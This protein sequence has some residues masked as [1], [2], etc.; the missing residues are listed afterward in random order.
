MAKIARANFQKVVDV[1]GVLQSY[2]GGVRYIRS[3][4]IQKGEGVAQL[5]LVGEEDDVTVPDRVSEWIANA[6]SKQNSDSESGMD[7]NVAGDKLTNAVMGLSFTGTM[8]SPTDG[9]FSVVY[10]SKGVT[11]GYRTG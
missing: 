6:S 11:P 9:R 2:W 4:L 5:S 1:L 10:P 3:V 8:H 7:R